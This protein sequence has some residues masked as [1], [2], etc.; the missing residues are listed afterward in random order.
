LLFAEQLELA[1]ELEVSLKVSIKGFT[2]P[3]ND[4]EYNKHLAKRR[5][6]SVKNFLNE[7]KNGLLKPYIEQGRLQLV[8]LP[9]GETMVQTG[10]SDNP[11]DRRQ[12]VY[13]ISAARERRIE[14]QSISIE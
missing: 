11:N 4:T 14:I 8:E 7:Y 9:F 5:I 10:V 13:S 2:S 3:L 6:A 1:M 12:S